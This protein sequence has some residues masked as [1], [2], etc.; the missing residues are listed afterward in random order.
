MKQ[1]YEVM[2]YRAL[3]WCEERPWKVYTRASNGRESGCAA[4]KS[5]DFFL[6]EMAWQCHGRADVKPRQCPGILLLIL[7]SMAFHCSRRQFHGL[8]LATM[9]C[10]GTAHHGG[11]HRTC[12]GT[13]VI[14]HGKCHGTCHGFNDD[15]CRG[16][17]WLA[18]QPM[19]SPTGC[20]VTQG[21]PWSLPRYAITK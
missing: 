12:H 3:A 8:P 1:A 21:S 10:D 5:F 17:P 15:T 13:P 18:M 7:N 14:C 19:V 16:G 4:G 2:A 6:C 9:A 20:H 11:C